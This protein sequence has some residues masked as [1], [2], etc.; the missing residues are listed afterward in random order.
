MG[1]DRWKKRLSGLGAKRPSSQSF[2]YSSAPSPRDTS[3]QNFLSPNNGPHP[4]AAGNPPSPSL[5]YVA[6]PAPIPIAWPLTYAVYPE[7]GVQALIFYHK[8]K[9]VISGEMDCW[10]YISKGLAQV[11]QK[12]IV[13]TIRR[14]A[15]ERED[16]L[17]I[18]PFQW[19]K[20]VYSAAKDGQRV[21][22]FQRTEFHSPSFLDRSDFQWIVY[23]PAHPITNIPASYFPTEWLQVIPLTAPEAEVAQKYGIMRALGHLGAQE[24]WFPF[25]PWINRDRQPCIT[26]ASMAGSVKDSIPLVVVRGISA[27]KRGME[28]VLHVPRESAFHLKHALTQFQLEHVF[29]LD[30]YHY[31]DADSGLLWSNTD[32][33]PRGYAAGTSNT[34]MN[35]NYFTFCPCQEKNELKM[36]E[37]GFIFM[38]T[39]Y[40][41]AS[42]RQYIDQSTSTGIALPS[43]LH[44]ILEFEQSPSAQRAAP[45]PGPLAT[46]PPPTTSRPGTRFVEYTPENPVPESQKPY[47]V[48]CD[49]IVLLDN[50]VTAAGDLDKLTNYIKS[51]EKVLDATVPKT[52]P[53]SAIGGGKLLIEADVGGPDRDDL[54]SREWVKV[55]FSPPPLEALPM[56][57]IYYGV[58]RVPKPDIVPRTK[59]S[60]AFNVWGFR[61]PWS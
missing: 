11:G 46:M 24:R 19:M 45:S 50:N 6:G 1:F 3:Q 57:Q 17:P 32:V 49:H 15:G 13:F 53:P 41:W 26:M 5:R 59:F 10:T 35:L 44:F 28:I 37:D 2:N 43:G 34:C 21:E 56:P 29:A 40:T 14:R 52:I 51:I 16:H 55:S 20:F 8:I 18:A 12:E 36:V 61:G 42:L 39:N 22:E 33:Q 23:C 38:I 4:A 47:H 48:H 7:E 54:L 58:S 60:L 27:L 30:S 31:K 25:P 9:S